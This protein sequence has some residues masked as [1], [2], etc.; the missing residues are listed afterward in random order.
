MHGL[1]SSDSHANE[2]AA[3]LHAASIEVRRAQRMGVNPAARLWTTFMCHCPHCLVTRQAASSVAA[4]LSSMA[5][6]IS[7]TATSTARWAPCWR[8]A[9]GPRGVDPPCCWA[10][11]ALAW[12]HMLL[13]RLQDLRRSN[14][15]SA[16]VRRANFKGAKVCMAGRAGG[17]PCACAPSMRC[18]MAGSLRLRS[19]G[20]RPPQPPRSAILAC[21]HC[22]C[23]AARRLFHEE[24]GLQDQLRGAS[25][26]GG[27]WVGALGG[28]AT[29][30]HNARAVSPARVTSPPPPPLAGGLRRM[31]ICR[32][33]S[34][35]GRS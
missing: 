34:W 27:G 25:P 8:W 3:V 28:R 29:K 1:P 11:E 9:T 10:G 21:A 2:R 17:G 35:T 22:C 5:K 13:R 23:A 18:V 30:E 19:L 26:W 4:A 20:G 12:A 16:D 31:P 15:T 24:R 33:C 14:F 7:R 32:T 6:P